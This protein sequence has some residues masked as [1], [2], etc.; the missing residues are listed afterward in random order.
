MFTKNPWKQII[1]PP[2]ASILILIVLIAGFVFVI[3]LEHGHNINIQ[4]PYIN[5]ALLFFALFYMAYSLNI[6]RLFLSYII[7]K[8][9]YIS[10]GINGQREVLLELY[11]LARQHESL[12]VKTLA[13]FFFLSIFGFVAYFLFVANIDSVSDIIYGKNEFKQEWQECS[14]DYECI[15]VKKDSICCYE[16]ISINKNH[17][18]SYAKYS[19]A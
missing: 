3:F 2:L 7:S 10:K 6:L 5:F 11:G 4:Q 12:I 8:R 14:G 19:E 16:I 18:E 13:V 15:L 17:N 9:K 1:Y